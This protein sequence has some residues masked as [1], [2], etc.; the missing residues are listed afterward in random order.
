MLWHLSAVKIGF[1]FTRIRFTSA[2]IVQIFN[3]I[4]NRKHQLVC[5]KPF[6]NKVKSKIIRHFSDNYSCLFKF[7]GH[8]KHLTRAYAVCFGL[9]CFYFRNGAWLPTPCVVNQ[10]F[11]IDTEEPVEQILVLN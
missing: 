5:N 8:L 2:D 4:T 6:L 3:I 10:Q 9:I 11:S 1:N 7:I